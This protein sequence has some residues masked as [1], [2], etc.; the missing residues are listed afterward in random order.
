MNT[1]KLSVYKQIKKSNISNLIPIYIQ[2]QNK[3]NKTRLSKEDEKIVLTFS[4]IRVYGELETPMYCLKDVSL[5][6]NIENPKTKIKEFDDD[7]KE[8]A[9]TIQTDGTKKKMILLSSQG[10]H[11]LIWA[12]DSI[13]STLFKKFSTYVINT[14]FIKKNVTMN[15]VSEYMIKNHLPLLKKTIKELKK[16]Y[17]KERH[18]NEALL[19]RINF[20]IEQEKQT[21]SD[22]KQVQYSLDNVVI[23]NIEHEKK[24]RL[25]E[26]DF[27]KLNRELNCS[28]DVLQ[29]RHVKKMYEK[30]T[31]PIYIY[32]DRISNNIQSIEKKI[33]LSK[34]GIDDYNIDDFNEDKCPEF[35]NNKL[36]NLFKKKDRTKRRVLVHILYGSSNIMF[37][38][39]SNIMYNEYTNPHIKN[40]LVCNIDDITFEFDDIRMKAEKTQA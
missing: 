36:Y 14:L 15:D 26:R 5:A 40:A 3:K 13:I 19:H 17:S 38:K 32:L 10:L 34:I 16:N 12:T 8:C 21:E 6:F 20:S 1:Q 29:Q 22:M 24:Y 7:E 37:E 28:P 4:I 30:Y 39:L 11:R 35:D 23:K 31:K 25:L 27:N 18:K 9:I 2:N 33:L